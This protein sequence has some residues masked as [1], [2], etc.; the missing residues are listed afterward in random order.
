MKDVQTTGETSS[1][2]KRTTSTLEENIY[3][4]MWLFLPT[5]IRVRIPDADPDLNPADQIMRIQ[6]LILDPEPWVS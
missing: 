4:F 1:P 3:F 2:Q 6:G 5:W